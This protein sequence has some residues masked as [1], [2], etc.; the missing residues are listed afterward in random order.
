MA[1]H[2]IPSDVALSDESSL[3]TQGAEGA[4]AELPPPLPPETPPP[5]PAPSPEKKTPVWHPG[6]PGRP[7]KGT[8]SGKSKGAPKRPPVTAPPL[9]AQLP[10]EL[11]DLSLSESFCL[12]FFSVS[13][14]LAKLSKRPILRL[15]L[16]E[17]AELGRASVPLARKYKWLEQVGEYGPEIG[18]AV[19]LG[20]VVNTRLISDVAHRNQG[21]GK[22]DA[23]KASLDG[24]GVTPET[25]TAPG[26]SLGHN[27]TSLL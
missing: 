2:Q 22:D 8:K 17:S 10:P 23:S 14:L 26:D 11:S 20:R 24:A 19:A 27:G 16:D 13:D 15:S 7:P 18:F 6:G 3:N 1:K 9:A 12:L 25:S 4:V 5:S 21:N